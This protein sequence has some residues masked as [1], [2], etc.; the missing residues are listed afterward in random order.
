MHIQ[1]VKIV[2]LGSMI[3]LREG[4]GLGPKARKGLGKMKPMFLGRASMG[5]LV[6]LGSLEC[7]IHGIKG[8]Y[9]FATRSRDCN[10]ID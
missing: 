7:V 6:S 8:A 2:G 9:A 5:R 1:K 10:I 3:L 4:F